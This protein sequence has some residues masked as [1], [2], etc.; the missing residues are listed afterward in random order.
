M[1]GSKH[2][3]SCV[4]CQDASTLIA[5]RSCCALFVADGAGSAPNS[6]YASQAAI[7]MAKGYFLGH[8][9]ARRPREESTWRSLLY[10]CAEKAR[11]AI[12][13]LVSE[14]RLLQTLR[15]T[16]LLMVI[17]ANGAVAV[18]IGDGAGLVIDQENAFTLLAPPENG[19]YINQT[20]FLTDSDWEE[21]LHMTYQPGQFQYGLACSDGLQFI[22]L[23]R[24]LPFPGFA[25]GIVTQLRD[26]QSKKRHM[27]LS[28]YLGQ[29]IIGKRTDDDVSLVVAWR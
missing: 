25:N 2:V 16:F 24:G 4:P 20:Y 15:T 9:T 17:D 27:A 23:H 7:E 12:F 28:Q 18:H 14:E 29:H 26:V 6:Q 19:E 10:A 13:N 21:H 11:E 1:Q 22:A 8:I 5:N 3:I